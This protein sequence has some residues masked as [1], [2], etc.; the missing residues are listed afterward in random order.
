MSES[1]FNNWFDLWHEC[2]VSK[3]C[4]NA[5]ACPQTLKV[6]LFLHMYCWREGETSGS[7][8]NT[9]GCSAARCL[10]FWKSQ[11]GLFS[12]LRHANRATSW[13]W[14]DLPACLD[15]KLEMNQSWW[16]PAGL[17]EQERDTVNG[18]QSYTSHNW[19]SDGEWLMQSAPK[20]TWLDFF[21]PLSNV[22]KEGANTRTS[23][24]FADTVHSAGFPPKCSTLIRPRAEGDM[25]PDIKWKP[26]SKNSKRADPLT[27]SCNLKNASPRKTTINLKGLQ[28]GPLALLLF[29][30]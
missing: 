30:T 15:I 25:F 17:E 11:F 21:L 13:G 16:K 8:G 24:T 9:A 3:S 19:S 27:M 12:F 14:G 28:K 10:F 26:F 7:T 4:S 23:L 20:F 18:T 22:E 1:A 29:C 2:F 6:H 5:P